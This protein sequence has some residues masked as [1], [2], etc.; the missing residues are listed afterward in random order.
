[1]E[2]FEEL[3]QAGSIRH[4]GISTNDVAAL[5]AIDAHGGC[6]SC[7]ISYSILSRGA[8]ADILPHCGK[9]NIGVLLRG[10]LAK[11]VLSGKFTPETRF[12][13]SVRERWNEGRER[14]R[15]LAQLAQVEQL[16]G[17]VREGRSMV[18]VALQF[19]LAHPAV[20]CPIPG[21]KTPEQARQNAAAADGE[22]TP[23]E[24]KLIDEISPPPK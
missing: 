19:T 23:E 16:Q 7:Q 15:F 21:M 13:D 8:E 17:L 4:Y 14:A 2:A 5:R 11:G 9:A 10:P 3:K 18:D 22:L 1:V 12:T 20:T 24:L 6:A